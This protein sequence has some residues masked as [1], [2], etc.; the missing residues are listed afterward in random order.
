MR[1][2]EYDSTPICTS[3]NDAR[4]RFHRVEIQAR[5]RFIKNDD[6]SHVPV[7]I[8]N[9]GSSHGETLPLSTRQAQWMTTFHPV[10]PQFR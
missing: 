1:D 4:H 7:T 9:N 3:A 10:E 6:V 5:C 2:H 8:I